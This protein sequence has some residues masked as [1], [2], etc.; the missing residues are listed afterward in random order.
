MKLEPDFVLFLD[1]SQ[2]VMI[3]R[4]LGRKQVYY[5]QLPRCIRIAYCKIHE[6]VLR[7][8]IYIKRKIVLYDTKLIL[9][10]RNIEVI[11]QN[12]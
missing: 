5:F 7:S 9:N 3:E 2:E 12:E 8:I 6:Q 10:G 1:C 4:I 11:A